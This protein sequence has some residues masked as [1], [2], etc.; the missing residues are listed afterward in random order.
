MPST[1]LDRESTAIQQAPPQGERVV[2]AK[3]VQSE[4]PVAVTDAG[5]SVEALT[6]AATNVADASGDVSR[7]E[8]AAEPAP[9]VT[10]PPAAETQPRPEALT[11]AGYAKVAQQL[12]V[13]LTTL[14]TAT[15]AQRG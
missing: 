15:L 12:G 11:P 2:A 7:T 1:V 14:R 5:A 8:V 6:A 4:A 3:A 13:S 10:E 9:Q